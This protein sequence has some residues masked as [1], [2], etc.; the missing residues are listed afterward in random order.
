MSKV[1]YENIKEGNYILDETGIYVITKVFP[2]K[3]TELKKCIL[4]DDGTLDID[5]KSYRYLCSFEILGKTLI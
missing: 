2:N 4:R 5:E 1:T 3:S